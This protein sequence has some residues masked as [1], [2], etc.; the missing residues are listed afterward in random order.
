MTTKSASPFLAQF[1]APIPPL[2]PRRR[3]YDARH[4]MGQ[5]CVD[6]AWIDRLD[7][8]DDDP[9]PTSFTR[10]RDETTDDE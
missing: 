9:Q 3:R 8:H 5:V 10:V 2:P 1:A 7:A 6:G 4:A